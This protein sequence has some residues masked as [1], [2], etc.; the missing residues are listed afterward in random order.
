M[1]AARAFV[2]LWPRLF[3]INLK[4]EVDLTLNAI[5]SARREK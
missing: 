3:V 1:I 2:G 4:L 5:Q